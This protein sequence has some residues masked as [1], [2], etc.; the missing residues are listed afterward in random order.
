MGVHDL[1]AG[2]WHPLTWLSHQADVS[3]YGLNKNTTGHHL[4]SVLFH[5]VNTVLLFLVLRAATGSTWRSAVVAAVWAVH[6]L[7]LE[8]VAWVSERKDVLSAFFWLL[9]MLA[10]VRYARRP[11]AGA[12]VLLLVLFAAGLMAKPMLVTLPLALLL[13]DYWPLGRCQATGHGLHETL[14]P[15]PLAP[16]TR[17]PAPGPRSPTPITRLILEKT[18]ILL[19]A[20]GSCA[21]A[22][23]AQRGWGNV[24]HYLP[25]GARAANAAVSY[26]AYVRKMLWPSDLAAYYP[27]AGMGIPGG[28]LSHAPHCLWPQHSCHACR[29]HRPHV[30]VGWFWYLMTLVPVIG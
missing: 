19:M 18:P 12:Y 7:R 1:Y 27:H 29:P 8:S 10:Y 11:S 3:L 5:A 28:R 16:D 4:T 14:P 20:L 17:H 24:S 22:L 2:N 30:S 9:S 13:L 6:P 21:V 15:R 25:Y 23:L 26:V